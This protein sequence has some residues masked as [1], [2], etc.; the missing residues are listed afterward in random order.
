V[1]RAPS[2]LGPSG[3]RLWRHLVADVEPSPVGRELLGEAC[4]LADECDR[5][6][7]E[8]AAGPLT[9]EGS[10]GQPRANP[11]LGE[12]RR[13]ASALRDLLSALPPPP[14]VEVEDAFAKLARE[15]DLT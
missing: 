9:V 15:L 1:R 7:F 2:G 14:P 11:L 8:L 10:M 6:R 12:I 4:K 13:H 3:R 5:L